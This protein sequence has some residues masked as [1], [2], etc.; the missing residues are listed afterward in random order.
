MMTF[1]DFRIGSLVRF[2][3]VS[4]ALGAGHD[5]SKTSSP[6]DNEMKHLLYPDDKVMYKKVIF[7]SQKENYR[8]IILKKMVFVSILKNCPFLR[9]NAVIVIYED[10]Y[11]HIPKQNSYTYL[12]G[13]EKVRLFLMNYI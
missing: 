2:F 1:L 9:K 12:K 6:D 7:I 11:I 3:S 10:S 13:R 4:F 5:D 8:Y